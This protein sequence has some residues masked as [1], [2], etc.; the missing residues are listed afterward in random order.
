MQRLTAALKHDA[1]RGPEGPAVAGGVGAALDR[2]IDA[3]PGLRRPLAQEGANSDRP[4]SLLL[5]DGLYDE[6][7]L[8]V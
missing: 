8:P 3:G 1:A 7:G 2:Y 4:L 6:R 5:Q